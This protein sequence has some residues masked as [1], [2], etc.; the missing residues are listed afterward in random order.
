M[1]GTRK[2][3]YFSGGKKAAAALKHLNL[4]IFPY[5]E[6]LVW[7]REPSKSALK[8]PKVQEQSALAWPCTANAQESKDCSALTKIITQGRSR[9]EQTTLRV[10]KF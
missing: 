4:F 8:I 9:T 6:G 1:C 2:W 10:F 5:T 7:H 3:K